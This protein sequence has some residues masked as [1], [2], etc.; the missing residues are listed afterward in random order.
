MTAAVHSIVKLYPPNAVSREIRLSRSDQ[1]ARR[2]KRGA[3]RSKV[4][5]GRAVAMRGA[6]GNARE[7]ALYDFDFVC[8]VD[9]L[10][11]RLDA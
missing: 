5:R 6:R 9:I 8:R 1:V 7:R 4:A 10:R 11:R 2:A 3:L